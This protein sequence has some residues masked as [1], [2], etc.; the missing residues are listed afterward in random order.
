MSDCLFLARKPPAGQGLLIHDISRS[1]K[2]TRH[3]RYDSSVRVISSSQRVQPE[4]TQHS[5]Q[6]NIHA[7]SGNPQPPAGER[8]QTHNLDRKTT[9]NDNELCG[10]L[11]YK[12][13]CFVV[14]NKLRERL[15]YCLIF[16]CRVE[17]SQCSPSGYPK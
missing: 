15:N 17:V 1:Q 4:R 16:E 12:N 7:P 14:N 9:G 8:P 6:T 11:E 13:L 3:S 10:W 5:K 2:T